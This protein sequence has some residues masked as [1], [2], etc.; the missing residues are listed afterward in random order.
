VCH[1][2]RWRSGA[3][4]KL[5]L[6]SEQR[7]HARPDV[8]ARGRYDF[9]GDLG[10]NY[11]ARH[12]HCFRTTLS[13]GAGMDIAKLKAEIESRGI[14]RAKIGGFDIDGVLRGKY[15]ALDKLYSVLDKG[16]GFCDVIFGWDVAD[17]L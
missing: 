17:V 11:D 16:F 7:L 1:D 13:S 14:K 4:Y 6:E 8:R 10:A 9:A 12:G 15:V 5:E 3:L 2:A